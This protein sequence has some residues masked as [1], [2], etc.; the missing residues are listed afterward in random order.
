[1]AKALASFSIARATSCAV[2]IVMAKALAS[3]G[4]S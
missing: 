2:S 4:Y 1:M 3:S